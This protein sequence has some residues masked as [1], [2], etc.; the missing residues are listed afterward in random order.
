MSESRFRFLEITGSVRR[1]TMVP[2]EEEPRA[3]P[4]ARVRFR[5]AETIGG[6]G[7]ELGYFNCPGGIA[8][9]AESNIYVAD[10]R[11]HRIQKITPHGEVYGLGGEGLLLCPQGVAVDNMGSLYIVEQGANRLQKFG[12]RGQ[13][14]FAIGGPPPV[15]DYRELYTTVIER[16][17]GADPSGVF[18]R[19]Y[20]ALDLV[21]A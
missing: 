3:E 6:P 10:S 16:W 21:R 4:V 19:R 2:V 5:V 15:I 18:A 7:A 12:P 1:P 14:L 11:N 13:W 8:V 17:W 9:D 20:P